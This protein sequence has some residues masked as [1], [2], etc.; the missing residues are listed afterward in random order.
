MAIETA[1]VT[2]D[3]FANELD[4]I[5]R[6]NT[7][8][9]VNGAAIVQEILPAFSEL[10]ADMSWLDEKYMVPRENRT[11]SAMLA[12]APDNA[13]TIV[14]TCFWPDYSTGVHDHLVWGLVGVWQGEE[15]EERYVRTDDRSR[16]GYAKMEKVGE[17]TNMPG[18]ISVLV[19][20]DEDY[21][22]IHNRLAVP[23]YSI[24]I[25][26][27]S[28]DGVLRN[29]YDMETGEIKGFRSTYQVIC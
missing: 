19:P 12:K 20:P 17:A 2:L 29:S 16:P 11:G 25:Y 26:G 14:S 4:R 24:H 8:G 22:L 6:A 21:H 15:Y 28:L 9:T 3:R 5:V 7:N 18:D 13:W 10:L 27:G 1:N 23:S